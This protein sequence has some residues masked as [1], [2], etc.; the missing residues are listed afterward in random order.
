M[1]L[2]LGRQPHPHPAHLPLI[3]TTHDITVA[4][5]IVAQNPAV[6]AS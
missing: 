5:K 6:L 2:W 4:V 1:P 3:C